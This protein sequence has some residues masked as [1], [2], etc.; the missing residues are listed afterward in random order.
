MFEIVGQIVLQIFR[1][2]YC[3]TRRMSDE[4][5]KKFCFEKGPASRRTGLQLPIYNLR[6]WNLLT[7]KHQQLYLDQLQ[8]A[9]TSLPLELSV[10]ATI[11]YPV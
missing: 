6:L 10:G 8:L 2:D 3:T 11:S 5:R 4:K 9:D 1:K 7:P